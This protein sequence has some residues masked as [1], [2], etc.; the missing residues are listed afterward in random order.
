MTEVTPEDV[1]EFY[2][3]RAVVEN[4]IEEVKDQFHLS[5]IPSSDYHVQFSVCMAKPATIR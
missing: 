5:K 4:R 3:G 2:N 1:W